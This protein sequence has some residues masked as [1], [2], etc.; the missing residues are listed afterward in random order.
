MAQRTMAALSAGWMPATG[1]AATA[2]AFL[3]SVSLSRRLSPGSDHPLFAL[4][5]ILLLLHEDASLFPSLSGPQRYAPPLAAVVASLCYS[6]VTHVLAGPPPP[7]AAAL[8]S[9]PTWPWM[10]KNFAA[11][12]ASTPNAACLVNYLWSYSRV[13][14]LT[15]ALLAPLNVLCVAIADVGAVRLLAGVSLVAA[16]GQYLMQRSVRLAGMRCL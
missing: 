1:N 14:G 2:I 9:T 6:A 11:L 7:V 3:V 10:L 4:A 8:R 13:R 16:A 5:P 15:L 12:L